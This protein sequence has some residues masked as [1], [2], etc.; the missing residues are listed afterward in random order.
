MRTQ[1]AVVSTLTLVMILLAGCLST[2]SQ[3]G[4]MTFLTPEQ[5]IDKT[6]TGGNDRGETFSILFTGD[7]QFT[8]VLAGAEYKGTWKYDATKTLMAYT[9]DWNKGENP[10][11]YLTSITQEK[12][13]VTLSGHWYLTDAYNPLY[14]SGT[15][16]RK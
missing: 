4:S 9:L 13:K 6:I 8:L 16:T 3:E 10:Q 11:G 15:F 12:D 14:L 1:I 7:N 2:G 5:L